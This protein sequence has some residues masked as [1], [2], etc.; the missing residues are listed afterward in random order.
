[1]R[2]TI[3]GILKTEK[4]LARSEIVAAFTPF[5]CHFTECR[6]SVG[7][8]DEHETDLIDLERERLIVIPR[9]YALDFQELARKTKTAT[10]L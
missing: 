6:R 4:W 8:K 10:K 5:L 3:S 9:Q 1:M 2:R 7:W